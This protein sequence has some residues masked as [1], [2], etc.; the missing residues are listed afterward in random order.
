MVNINTEFPTKYLKS[1][2]LAGQMVRV[3][4]SNVV[5][6]NVGDDRKL[7]MYF[8]GKTKGMIVNKTNAKTLAEVFGDETDNWIGAGIEIF[9]MK[10]DYQGRMVDG[11]RVRVPAP[12]PRRAAAAP[13]RQAPAEYDDGFDNAPAPP[14]PARPQGEVRFMANAAEDARVARAAPAPAPSRPT[15]GDEL[16]DQEIPF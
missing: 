10:V 14:V 4:I 15:L 11:L 9:S 13:Q 2:D 1:S 7:I 6:E 16:N 3:K 8:A 5:S 12:P